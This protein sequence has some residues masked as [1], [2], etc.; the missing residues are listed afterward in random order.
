MSLIL[1]KTVAQLTHLELQLSEV[2]LNLMVTYRECYFPDLLSC[3]GEVYLEHYFY[4]WIFHMA[5]SPL[6]NY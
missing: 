4:K 5:Q 3:L 6:N 2:E 1:L